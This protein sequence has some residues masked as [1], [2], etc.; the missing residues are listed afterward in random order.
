MV[1]IIKKANRAANRLEI[2]TKPA[3]EDE[4]TLIEAGCDA[5]ASDGKTRQSSKK[6]LFPI[7]AHLLPISVG[8]SF[9]TSFGATREGI[10]VNWDRLWNSQ[11]IIC[12]NHN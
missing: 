12:P 9:K 4:E 8:L 1:K 6:L 2:L 11:N 3:A 5:S 10:R 7:P